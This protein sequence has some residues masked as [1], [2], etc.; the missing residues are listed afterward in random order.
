MGGVGSIN[1]AVDRYPSIQLV[2]GCHLSMEVTFVILFTNNCWIYARYSSSS[3]SAG[4]TDMDM[5]V[6]EFEFGQQ[7]SRKSDSDLS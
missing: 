5:R 3:S 6:H 7:K 4:V 1:I 2:K